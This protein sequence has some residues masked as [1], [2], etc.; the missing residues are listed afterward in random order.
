MMLEFNTNGNTKQRRVAELWADSVTTE[1]VYGGAKGGGKS[2]LGCS[3]ILGSA[4]TYP[5]TFYFIARKQLKDIVRFTIPSIEEVLGIWEIPKGWYK[6]QGM[7]H[8]YEFRNGSRVYLID[9]KHLP[10]DPMYERFG[11]MQMTQGW[12]EEAGEFT[13]DAKANLGASIGRWNNDVY[14][15]APKLLMTCN[16]SHNFLYSDYYRPYRDGELPAWVAFVQAFPQDNKML[17]AGY[18]DNLLRTLSPAQIAR[19]VHGEWEFDDDPSWLVDYDAICDLFTN[20][21]IEP[22]GV[23]YLVTDLAGKGRDNWVVSVWDG[24]VVKFPI[25]KGFS[26]AKEM[27]EAIRATA[28]SNGI[29]RSRIVS[30]ADGLGFWLE[31]YMRGIKEFKGGMRANEP[32]KYVNLKSECAY[33]LA[34]KINKREIYIDCS[35]ELEEQIKSEL[36]LLR[37]HN[38][39]TTEQRRD[40]IK[41]DVM[42]ER[43]GHSPDFLDVLI[44]R[45]VFDVKPPARGLQTA[46]IVSPYKR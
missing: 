30:D 26:E 25:V 32:D 17:P 15:I 41:K 10:S 12:I 8:Y 18:I 42:R 29:A 19:L 37:A 4:L 9:A 16:P 33:K 1:I 14:N 43:L 35:R 5:N 44:M 13:R 22:S 7:N 2:F 20:T 6:Y 31:S 46:R 38:L 23:K 3:L 39:N 24:D 34:E 40:I 11:S 27:E 36:Q 28:D 45:Q 21:H